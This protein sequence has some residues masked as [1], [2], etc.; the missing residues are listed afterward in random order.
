MTVFY[1][2]TPMDEDLAALDL[3]YRESLDHQLPH[4]PRTDEEFGGR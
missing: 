3:K 4:A 2:R 1:E